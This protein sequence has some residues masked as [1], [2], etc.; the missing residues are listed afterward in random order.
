LV[1]QK[2]LKHET[3]YGLGLYRLVL[4][5]RASLGLHNVGMSEHLIMVLLVLWSGLV[6]DNINSTFDILIVQLIHLIHNEGG[7]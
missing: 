4:A 2:P 3:I 6:L 7:Y 1:G 5:Y